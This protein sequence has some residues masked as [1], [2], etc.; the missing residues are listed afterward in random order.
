MPA[1][2]AD[3][4]IAVATSIAATARRVWRPMPGGC[5]ATGRAFNGT[6][7]AA[8][9]RSNVLRP[10]APPLPGDDVGE[11]VGEGGEAL[12]A[13]V[14]PPARLD[15]AQR[16]APRADR[17]PALL[18]EPDGVAVELHVAVLGERLGRPLHAGAAL[19]RA[20]GDVGDRRAG[21]RDVLEQRRGLER[22]VGEAGDRETVVQLGEQR[23]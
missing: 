8:R 10:R 5:S 1:E 6:L 19:L 23:A 18:G 14:G 11:H 3:G 9:D 13:D 21:R 20:G 16:L 12:V 22:Q 2:A 17:A 7:V 4:A 15:L